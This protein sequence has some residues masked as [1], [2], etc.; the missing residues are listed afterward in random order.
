MNFL[1]LQPNNQGGLSFIWQT[2]AFKPL[3]NRMTYPKHVASQLWLG[4]GGVCPDLTVKGRRGRVVATLKLPVTR[5]G[6]LW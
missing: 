1:I 4:G 2:E 3:Y 5:A 6:Q